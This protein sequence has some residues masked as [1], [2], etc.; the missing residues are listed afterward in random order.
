MVFSF[1][2]GDSQFAVVKTN[3][4]LTVDAATLDGHESDKDMDGA[5][6]EFSGLSALL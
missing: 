3:G 6:E 4:A 5:E 2:I 1:V